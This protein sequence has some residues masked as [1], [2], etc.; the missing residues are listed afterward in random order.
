M[1]HEVCDYIQ[2]PECLDIP[3]PLRA[4]IR[5][6]LAYTK[7]KVCD[8]APQKHIGGGTDNGNTWLECK[9][10][11]KLRQIVTYQEL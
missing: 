1:K 6:I 8:H 5:T 4:A 3:M 10:G 2:C 11:V 7:P 9:C